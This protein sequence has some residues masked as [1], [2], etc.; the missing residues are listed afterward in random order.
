MPQVKLYN[1]AN[2]LTFQEP[3][4]VF[5]GRQVFK[6]HLHYSPKQWN[7]VL[8]NPLKGKIPNIVGIRWLLYNLLLDDTH[9]SIR[10]EV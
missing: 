9:C 5:A 7:C 6:W 3:N 8:Y 10:M 4:I 1:R 2:S